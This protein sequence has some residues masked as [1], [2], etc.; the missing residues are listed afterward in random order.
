VL[1]EINLLPQ[2]QPKSSTTSRLVILMALVLI[3][4]SL[5]ILWQ[6]QKNKSEINQLEANIASYEQSIASLQ[7]DVSAE[8]TNSYVELSNA[9]DWSLSYPIKSV[10]V[11]KHLNSLLPERGFLLSYSYTETGTISLN[12]QFDTKKEAAYY[13][14]WLNDSE[15]IEDVKL[16]QLSSSQIDTTEETTVEDTSEEITDTKNDE[17]AESYLPRYTGSFEITLNKEKIKLS[18]QVDEG[19]EIDEEGGNE[20]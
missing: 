3:L 8:S 5:F 10:A 15:W 17:V 12:V 11:L 1:V 2:K 6:V 9:V 18:E 20:E 7:Q 4:F 19:T 13:L 16:S 14:K